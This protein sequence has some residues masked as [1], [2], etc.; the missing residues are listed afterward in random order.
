MGAADP[1][2]PSEAGPRGL[3]GARRRG[4][5]RPQRERHGRP[6]LRRRPG[7]GS[8]PRGCCGS[9]AR[10]APARPSSSTRRGRCRTATW[11]RRWSPTATRSA[12]TATATCAT[13]S[14][15]DG[16]L[17]RDLQHGPAT[18]SPRL[19]VEPR[20]WRAPWGVETA[21]TRAARRRA[22][23]R[24][25]GLEPR[26]PRLARRLRAADARRR[27]RPQGGLRDGDVVLMHD[28]LGPGARRA[29]LRGDAGADRAR[30]SSGRRGA[31]CGPAPVSECEG[32]RRERLRP[33]A[34]ASAPSSRAAAGPPRPGARRDRGRRRGARPRA[35][36]PRRGVRRARRGRRA[37]RD[38]GAAR[39]D[40]L[41]RAR[42][43]PGAPGRRRRRLGRRGSSTAT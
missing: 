35:A 18:S 43:G 17:E 9:C 19:G 3:A 33:R 14:R 40:A 21:A 41:G 30:C 24:A 39:A 15:R 1:G 6:H 38:V 8:G 28:G 16:E 31:A 20:A 32:V 10:P 4:G 27:S 37:D 42:V 2:A 13:P 22:R 34:T 11:S 26:Q 29:G 5:R 23:P 25:L 7:P 12:S 36:L